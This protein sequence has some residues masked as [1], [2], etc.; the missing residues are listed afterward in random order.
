MLNILVCWDV[1]LHGWT[2]GSRHF[3]I[4]YGLYLPAVRVTGLLEP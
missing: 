2:G 1:M 4:S 3:G